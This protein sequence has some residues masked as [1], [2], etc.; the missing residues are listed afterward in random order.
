MQSNSV[1]VLVLNN[2]LYVN[3][4]KIIKRGNLIIHDASGKTIFKEQIEETNYEVI[5]LDQP[6]GK[7]WITIDSENDLTKKTFH[8]K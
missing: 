2:T 4:G 3:L 5:K 8:L 6:Q 7:Y 1:M